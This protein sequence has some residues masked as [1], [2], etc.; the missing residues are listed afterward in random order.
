LHLSSSTSARPVHYEL[1]RLQRAVKEA[2]LNGS[3]SRSE[4]CQCYS[5]A[6]TSH[7]TITVDTA[8]TAYDMTKSSAA[9]AAAATTYAA[10]A[11][12]Y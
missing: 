5:A 9:I 6:L 4:L 7:V 12:A 2:V 10:H 3:D 11:A 8:P 1:C